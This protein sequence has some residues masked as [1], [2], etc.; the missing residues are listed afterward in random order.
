MGRKEIRTVYW[1][2][3]VKEKDHLEDF[4]VDGEILEWAELYSCDW[5]Q[6]HVAKSFK[7]SDELKCL[8]FP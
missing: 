1:W 4:G 7:R 8:K 5:G 3:N 6:G 2:R